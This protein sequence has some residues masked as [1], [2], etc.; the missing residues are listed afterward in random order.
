MPLARASHFFGHDLWVEDLDELPRR[1][2]AVYRISRVLYLAWRGFLHDNGLHRAS[3]LAFD[4][5]LGLIPFLAFVVAT[6]KG[7]GSYD[8]LMTQTVRP[9][10]DAVLASMG[11]G[12]D[13]DVVNLRTTFRTLL[14]FLDR[15]DFGGLGTVG[16]IAL[17]YITVLMLVSI[18][19]SM[20]HIFGAVR[21]RSVTRRISDYSA[22]LFIMPIFATVAA[23]VAAAAENVTWPAAGLVLQFMSVLAMSFGLTMMYLVMPFV[24]VR[25]GPAVLGGGVAGVL[26]YL[27]LLLHVH[28]QIG[29]ARYNAIYS[30]F[31]AIPLFFIWVFFSWLVVLF[32]AELT[33]AQQNPSAF[34]FRVCD[35][36]VDH[37]ARQFIALR[38]MLAIAEAF[39]RGN[40][41]LLLSELARICHAPDKLVEQIL[42]VF[43][44][45]SFVARVE[46]SGE[47][48]YLL[49][50]DLA[51]TDVQT[52]LNAVEKSPNVHAPR[53]DSQAASIV[54]RVLAGMN[55]ARQE[56]SQNY[57]LR[58]LVNELHKRELVDSAGS[59]RKE[60]DQRD[61]N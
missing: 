42:D 9:W 2:A 34:R 1:R 19:S 30:T 22:I 23:A 49:I 40:S 59:E 38:C 27:T 57:T 16:L 54:Q 44:E 21:S 43:A 61:V 7:F 56:S 6:L 4:T 12:A 8:R 20:N 36:P 32:G 5:G 24:R 17:L 53:T 51:T 15:V 18:E 37:A 47:G 26:W 14:E 45:Q 13:S 46:R 11:D 29:V 35:S 25:L 55:S 58:E 50:R 52:L 3:A 33:A 60:F 31:A 39:T 48:S 41:P 28:F 10:L